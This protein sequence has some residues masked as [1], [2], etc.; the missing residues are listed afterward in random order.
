MTMRVLF[1]ERKPSGGQSIEN[2]FR[3]VAAKLPADVVTEFQQVPFGNGIFAIIGNLLFFR[4]RSADIYHVTGDVHYITLR[5]PGRRTVLTIH[6]LIFLRRRRG[7]RRFVLKKLFLTWPLARCRRITAVSQATKDEI[8][9]ETGISPDRVQVI[10]NPLMEAIAQQTV[11]PKFDDECP[12]ILH[13]GTAENKNLPN[14]VRALDGFKCRLRVIGRV[15]ELPAVSEAAIENVSGLDSAGMIDEY[16]RADIVAFCSTYEG[17]GLPI[18]EAQAMR[19]PVITSDLA[20]MRE[21]AGGASVLVDPY[22]PESIRK[23]IRE[24]IE[25]SKLRGAIVAAGVENAKR[26]D[27]RRIAREYQDIYTSVLSEGSI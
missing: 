10:D 6:D 18:I 14:L 26:F 5:L 27:G 13:I 22:E 17:F 15:G 11:E 19:R 7:P 12:T 3:E 21:V 1:V 20:P 4:P 16:R 23:G 9:H 24:V 25:N 8:V 2:V